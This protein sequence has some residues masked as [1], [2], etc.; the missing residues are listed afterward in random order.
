MTH[1][2][3]SYAIQTSEI[4]GTPIPS[5]FTREGFTIGA[6]DNAD[7]AD[8]SSLS[9]KQNS[10]DSV[11]VM[12]Q[13]ASASPPSKPPVSST[14]LSKSARSLNVLLPCQKVSAHSKPVVRPSLPPDFRLLE[15]TNLTLSDSAIQVAV[16]TEFMISF[17]RC[18]IP[19]TP[20]GNLPL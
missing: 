1:L 10:H 2:L 14:Q 17:V 12:F 3:A 5:H 20:P 11:L 8:N 18:G 9:S 15:D 13:E 16:K 7:F 4:Y 19:H 6:L